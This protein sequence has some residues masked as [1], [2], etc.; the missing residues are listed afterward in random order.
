MET[1]KIEGVWVVYFCDNYATVVSIWSSELE[2]RRAADSDQFYYVDFVKFGAEEIYRE[3][4][5]Q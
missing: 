2:A 3:L 1:E 5:K 4:N